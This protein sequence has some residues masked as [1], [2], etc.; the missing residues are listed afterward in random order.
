M[1]LLVLYALFLVL[2]PSIYI[3]E[4]LGGAGTPAA[5][6]G[7]LALLLWFLRQVIGARPSP[8]T[9]VHWLVWF[10]AAAMV[11]GF[12]AGALRPTT[13]VEFTAS[14][15]GFIAVASW[16]G[17]ALTVMDGLR[18][19]ERLEAFLRF[20]VWLG[21]LLA[22]LGIAQFVTGFDV[23]PWLHVP[24]LTDNSGVLGLGERSGFRRVSGTALH[25][26]EYSAVLAMI[27]P[28]AFA[29]AIASRVHRGRAWLP[30]LLMAGVLPLTVARS[31]FLGLALALGFA[32]LMMSRRQRLRLVLLLP[33]LA[34]A[35]RAAVPGLLGTIRGLFLSAGEDISVTGRTADYGAVADFVRESPLF[36][37]G[38]FTFQPAIY[39]ILDNQYLLTA[40]EAGLVGCV[41][42]VLV[43][44]VPAVVSF[45]R[46]WLLRTAG[47]RR[48][49]EQRDEAA[50][51]VPFGLGAS[52]VAALVL[53]G[54]FDAF[55]FPMGMGV[56]SIVLGASG[57]AWRLYRP[58]G[59]DAPAPPATTPRSRAHRRAGAAAALAT[60]A[61]GLFLVHT[62]RPSYDARTSFALAV[63]LARGQSIITLQ[64]GTNA[65][66]DVV[67]YSVHS[68]E[69]RSR[70]TREGAGPYTV[71]I[72]SG[73]LGPHTD[74]LGHGNVL[75]VSGIGS[76]P[77][78]AL[79]TVDMAVGQIRAELRDWQADGT[80]NGSSAIAV[81]PLETPQ[82]REV[83]VRRTLGYV[84][85]A[86]LTAVVGFAASALSRRR[87]QRKDVTGAQGHGP[88]RRVRLRPASPAPSADVVTS[89]R[90]GGADG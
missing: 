63:P 35:F 22:V 15:R 83:P 23:V 30:V 75:T 90:R 38:L 37:R 13:G 79:D 16:I 12:T 39:R 66:S 58:A 76:D 88:R 89:V 25:S 77:A 45:R 27:L 54:T 73:S 80:R 56:F 53:F 4:P 42:L 1:G 21:A 82:A 47:A 85:V 31:G 8:L 18:T 28:I 48:P 70:L 50:H 2:L 7:V 52:L 36:G 9:P 68:G 33:F 3:L 46:A 71:A 81:M 57:A 72:G 11:A 55:S 5:V 34:V 44:V 49:P 51:L 69:V 62:A 14:W 61:V 40:V 65:L 87:R 24:G 17:V 67:R 20:V 74:V 43:I 41:A 10:F 59:P 64:Q 19:R 78:A 86:A 32:F 29:Q 60:L 6:V 26:I 84:G